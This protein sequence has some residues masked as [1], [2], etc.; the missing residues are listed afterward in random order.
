MYSKATAADIFW[1]MFSSAVIFF[2]R[3][4]DAIN[5]LNVFPVP[6]GD[7]GTNMYG[8]LEGI[9]SRMRTVEYAD[10]RELTDLLSQAAL[11]EGRGN[12]GIILS[13]IFRGLAEYLSVHTS[14]VDLE[15]ISGAIGNAR[16]KAFDSVAEPTEGTMLTVLSDVA[17]RADSLK[18]KEISVKNLFKLL[19][20]EAQRSVDR[21]PELLPILKDSGVVDSGGYG[22]EVI[23]EGMAIFLTDTDPATVPIM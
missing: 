9:Q 6:D 8:T 5:S 15:I 1:G 18:G 16:V 2:R 10:L 12:S 13:Q 22:I 23:L 19:V 14:E 17:N 7:T 21:T 11:Y 20:E 3:H 4:V